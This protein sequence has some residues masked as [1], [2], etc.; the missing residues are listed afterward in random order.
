MAELGEEGPVQTVTG[1]G[2][3]A[4]VQRSRGENRARM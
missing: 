1:D 4:A 2:K 3:T